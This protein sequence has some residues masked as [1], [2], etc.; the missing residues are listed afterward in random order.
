MPDRTA[1]VERIIDFMIGGG[2]LEVLRFLFG[3]KKNDAETDKLVSDNWRDY[4]TKLEFRFNE[5]EAKFQS[6][7]DKYYILLEEHYKLKR[8]VNAT[9]DHHNSGA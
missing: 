6:L 4:A 1:A 8:E 7:S 3:K 2:V 9:S 5:L